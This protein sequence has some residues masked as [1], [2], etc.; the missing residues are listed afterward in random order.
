MSAMKLCPARES[1]SIDVTNWP[2]AERRRL[3]QSIE[4]IREEVEKGM[5]EALEPSGWSQELLGDIFIMLAQEGADVQLLAIQHAHHH[6]GEVSRS[7]V[8]SLGGYPEGRQLKGFTR[9]CNR[10]TQKLRD[11]GRIPQDAD[12]LLTPVYSKTA[13]GYSRA[14]GFRIPR[15]LVDGA[16]DDGSETS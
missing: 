16:A 5:A 6:G 7:E 10:V 13:A 1:I 9:P 11:A 4:T 3:F 14:L 2:S 12:E 8:F 15:E